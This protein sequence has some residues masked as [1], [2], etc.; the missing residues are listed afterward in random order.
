MM[1]LL[2]ANHQHTT[3]QE[4]SMR[5][6]IVTEFLS[7]DGVMED[8]AWTGPYWNDEIATFKTDETTTSDA[9]LLGRVTYQGFAAAWP[10]SP[11]PGAEYFNSVRKYVVST[12]LDSAEWNNSTLLKHDIVQAITNLKQQIGQDI[13][14]HGSAALAQTLVQHGLVDRY[15]LLIY[16]VIIGSGKRL[17]GEGVAAT[18]RLVE[19][20]TFSSGVVALVYEPDRN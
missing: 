13:T 4:N 15:H 5:N 6:L 14:V 19:S 16:P 18:L 17:F 3:Q 7:L 9:L 8:P 11:D 1:R 12:T 20:R 2:A 10:Q